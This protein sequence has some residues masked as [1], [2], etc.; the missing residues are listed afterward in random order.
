MLYCLPDVFLKAKDSTLEPVLPA[1]IIT[2]YAWSVMGC[3]GC[4]LISSLKKS[5]E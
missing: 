5:D 4:I 2:A 1:S 3:G